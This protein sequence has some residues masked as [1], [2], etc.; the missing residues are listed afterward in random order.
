MAKDPAFLF[1]SKDWIEGT[2]EYFPAEKGVYVDLLA[3]QHQKGL[4]PA[5]VMRLARIVGLS[6]EEFTPIWD[7]IKDKFIEIEPGKLA[8]KR[9]QEE[10][11]DRK[12]KGH[13]NKIIGQF[14]TLIRQAK[15][16]AKEKEEIKKSF[17]VTE[18]LPFSTE[19]A[20]ELLTEWF[21]K[22]LPSLEDGN[23]NAIAIENTTST[24]GI[25]GDP[26]FKTNPKPEDVGP[27]PEI[28]IRAAIELVFFLKHT[29]LDPPTVL[30]G[31]EIF[32]NIHLTGSNFYPNESAVHQHFINWLKKE[33]LKNGKN[34]WGNNKGAISRVGQSGEFGKI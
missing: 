5:D 21:Y 9:L 31:Y 15:I 11:L 23:G 13:K 29:T 18:F 27:L 24:V 25:G 22:R 8:N 17:N 3:H 14:A 30:K 10:I 28:K 20:T 33:D 7:K 2:A 19:I 4:L 16:S 32:K 1:Y 6:I 34:N 26:G 12:E